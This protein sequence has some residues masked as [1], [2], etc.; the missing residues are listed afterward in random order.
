MKTLRFSFGCCLM[1]FACTFAQ[2]QEP[3]EIRPAKNSLELRFGIR[4]FDRGEVSLLHGPVTDVVAPRTGNADLSIGF[5]HRI[6]A[7]W[8]WCVR[9][10]WTGI[11]TSFRFITS[12]LVDTTGTLIFEGGEFRGPLNEM[13]QL[14]A[15][16]ELRRTIYEFGRSSFAAFGGIS[17]LYIQEYRYNV[18]S[19]YYEF[20]S[21]FLYQLNARTNGKIR[22]G[23]SFGVRYEHRFGKRSSLSL[24]VSRS[25]ILGDMYSG[26]LIIAPGSVNR[27]TT[28][29]TQPSSNWLFGIGYRFCLDKKPPKKP[30]EYG[31]R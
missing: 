15:D 16:G 1:L 10:S 9:A 22:P 11:P 7:D 13:A 8:T 19:S 28:T 27:S 20:G 3:N 31:S 4:M 2:A 14:N 23:M 30:I 24:D 17:A 26:T 29:V 5:S 25:F 12:R 6:D 18:Y 21:P